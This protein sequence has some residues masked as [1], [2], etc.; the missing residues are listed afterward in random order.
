MMNLHLFKDSY[1]LKDISY[2]VF[3]GQR[4]S[5]FPKQLKICILEEMLFHL[6]M[7]ENEVL[8]KNRA[9]I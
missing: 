9:S 8:Q 6:L 7:L 5:C 1:L 2:L 3:Q 4:S